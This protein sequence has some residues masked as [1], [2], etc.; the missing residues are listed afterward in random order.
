MRVSLGAYPAMSL[1]TAR[2]A[3]IDALAALNAGRNPATEK[4]EAQ[5]QAM[6]ERA[7]PDT[8]RARWRQ[9][10]DAHREWG[11]RH[12][13][14][15]HRLGE[16]YVLPA[17]GGRVLRA[18]VRSDW[19]GIIAAIRPRVPGQ[20]SSLYAV[21]SSFD[22]FA[23]AMG[24]IDHPLLP[25]RGRNHIAP[26]PAPRER[27]LTD[28]ELIA[29][30]RA[31]SLLTPRGRALVRLLILTGARFN[32]IA[33]MQPEELDFAAGR[34]TLPA[35]RSKNKRSYCLP[36]GPLALPEIETLIAAP[37]LINAS[38]VKARLDQLS[39]VTDWRLHDLR[40]TVRTGL[41]GLGT[42]RE[43]AEACLNHVRDRG[44]VV[45]VYD[46]H[47]YTPEIAQAMLRWHDRVAEI[48]DEG[49]ATAE[50]IRLRA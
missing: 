35:Q 32:E 20:A 27:V 16:Q 23:E 24:W 2:A 21:I 40:R 46:R 15:V 3:A 45:G 50:V 29:V 10:Q 28:D 38:A 1:K 34:W 43:I 14:T 12:A 8:V 30:W 5:R 47:N 17:L 4:R 42:L 44:G 9:W 37:R 6:V 11:A 48:I 25:R 13:D 49:S 7:E 33:G 36:I 26:M 22:S 31:A 39:G 19:T 18:T 41:A